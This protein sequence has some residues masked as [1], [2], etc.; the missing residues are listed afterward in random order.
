[1][2]RVAPR[3]D[4]ALGQTNP[5]ASLPWAVSMLVIICMALS[6]EIRM[7]R[8][9]RA[10]YESYSSGAPFMLPL[11]GFLSRAVSAPFGL[12]RGKERPE[13]RW[14]PVCTFAI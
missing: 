1:M 13:T 10:E 14:D 12:I 9:Q 5:G 6:E 3:R 8:Q 2:L 11:P 7:R 4:T